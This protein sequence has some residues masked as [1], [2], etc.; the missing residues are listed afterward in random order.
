MQ[1]VHREFHTFVNLAFL[2][3]VTRARL[4]EFLFLKGTDGLEEHGSRQAG[5]TD[6]IVLAHDYHMQIE[7]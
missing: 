6:R 7:S 5:T 3:E 2:S 4:L 1:Q